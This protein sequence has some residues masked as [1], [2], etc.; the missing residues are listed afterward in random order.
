M[1]CEIQLSVKQ[2]EKEIK[3]ARKYTKKD[4]L[5]QLQVTMGEI[6]SLKDTLDRQ[7]KD[8]DNS[9]A[10]TYYD[11]IYKLDGTAIEFKEELE[12]E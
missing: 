4:L 11:F 2:N 6:E 9:D 5:K 10:T 3:M 1:G 7:W 8:Y 12:G